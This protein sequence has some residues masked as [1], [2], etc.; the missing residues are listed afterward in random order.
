LRLRRGRPQPHARSQFVALTKGPGPL[1]DELEALLAA[2]ASPTSLHRFFAA[3]PALLRER[4]LSHQ[5]LVTTSYD[6]AL[7]QALLD[8]GEEFDVVSYVATGRDRGKFCHRDPGGATRTIDIPNTYATELS[9]D[10]RT[11]VLK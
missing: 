5:L 8:A 3:L 9:L 4:G 10:R 2:A 11:I 6:L 1:H 7:E